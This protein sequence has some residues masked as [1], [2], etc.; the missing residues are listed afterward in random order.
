MVLTEVKAD[1]S[2]IGKAF[3]P[4]TVCLGPTEKH[5]TSADGRQAQADEAGECRF[6]LSDY[7]EC[8]HHGAEVDRQ[9]LACLPITNH[10]YRYAGRR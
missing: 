5:C 10:K 2:R 7:M 8:L 3:W 4:A 9:P 6:A 1:V